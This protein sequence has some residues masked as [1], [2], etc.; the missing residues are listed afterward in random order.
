MA[1]E[2]IRLIPDEAGEGF[3]LDAKKMLDEAKCVEFSRMAIIGEDA[4][5]NLYIAGTAN[6]GETLVLMEL[7]KRHIVF[8]E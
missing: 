3:R 4:E 7:A 6:A 1:A 5:G 2:I 8:G